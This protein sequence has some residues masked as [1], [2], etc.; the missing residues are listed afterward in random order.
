[1]A[2]LKSMISR[3]G[4]F[5]DRKRIQLHLKKTEQDLRSK[6]VQDL[7]EE[8]VENRKENIERLR[9]YRE[10]GE[11][12]V[13]PKFAT[14]EPYFVDDSGTPCA[15]A[16]LIQESGYSSLVEEVAEHNN[17]VYLEEL[18]GG[19]VVDW[20]ESS[21]LSKEE[22][23]RIQ[24]NYGSYSHV[25]ALATNCG[26]FSCSLALATLSLVGGLA[27]LGLEW[28]SYRYARSFYPDKPLKSSGS[29]IGFSIINVMI[30][31]L[32]VMVFYAFLP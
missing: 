8:E 1:M 6:D 16:Y 26:S 22:A 25:A 10:A 32:G 7:S 20:I 11:F 24:P 18:S 17:H 13:N 3:L 12:P 5:V 27:F 2:S 9:E 15:M 14:R 23:E 21:G 28:L 31:T 4:V 29:F 30:T 19:P